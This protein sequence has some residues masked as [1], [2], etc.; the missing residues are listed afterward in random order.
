MKF[1]NKHGQ[2]GT[3]GLAIIVV[4]V[5]IVS[6]MFIFFTPKAKLSATIGEK[7]VPILKAYQ[8]LEGL[9]SYAAQAVRYSAYKALD[10][11]N[12]PLCFSGLDTDNFD[13]ALRKNMREYLGA[14]LEGQG[15]NLELPKDYDFQ[16][17]TGAD[18]LGLVGVADKIKVSS[19]DNTF[20]ASAGANVQIKVTCKEYDNYKTL[21]SK[22]VLVSA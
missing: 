4:I 13:F 9:H 22:G 16:I 21:K 15:V 7:Q 6:T 10:A 18:E 12:L 17:S 2:G 1:R 5:V 8:D 3:K 19:K 11:A 20:T 14:Q